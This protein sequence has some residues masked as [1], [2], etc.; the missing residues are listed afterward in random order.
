MVLGVPIC[1]HFRVRSG[2]VQ[3]GVLY[4]KM[5]FYFF[6][7][8]LLHIVESFLQEGV[9]CFMSG[10]FSIFLDENILCDPA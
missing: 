2:D 8:R 9:T 6:F 10:Q 4:I 1:K 7:R 5:H 3:V